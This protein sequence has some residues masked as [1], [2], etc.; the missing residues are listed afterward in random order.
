MCT[1]LYVLVGSVSAKLGSSDRVASLSQYFI[2][3]DLIELIYQLLK[4]MLIVKLYGNFRLSVYFRLISCFYRI[5]IHK[6]V[7]KLK[8]INSLMKRIT[9]IMKRKFKQYIFYTT[10]HF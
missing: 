8:Q 1:V 2:S 9:K 6:F 7:Q 3:K 5:F 10:N 4:I